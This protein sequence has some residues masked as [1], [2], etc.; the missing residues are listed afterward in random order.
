MSTENE[1]RSGF[2]AIVGRP[3]TGKSTLVKLLTKEIETHIENIKIESNYKK[4]V[5]HKRLEEDVMKLQENVSKLTYERDAFESRAFNLL[6][7]I[8][9]MPKTFRF[10]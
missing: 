8:L 10:L 4:E 6:T 1:F 5:I 3:N 9:E 2:V 7:S